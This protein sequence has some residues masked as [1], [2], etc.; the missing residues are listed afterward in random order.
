MFIYKRCFRLTLIFINSNDNKANYLNKY[1]QY[2]NGLLNN[3]PIYTNYLLTKPNLF[4]QHRYYSSNNQGSTL[5]FQNRDTL[6]EETSRLNKK[7]KY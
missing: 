6:R 5:Y 2:S 3:L 4:I 7:I 1:T